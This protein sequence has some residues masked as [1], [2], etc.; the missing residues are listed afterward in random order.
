M[1]LRL[2]LSTLTL[3]NSINLS[4]LL[5]SAS[6]DSIKILSPGLTIIVLFISCL[7]GIKGI[8]AFSDSGSSTLNSSASFT[9]IILLATGSSFFLLIAAMFSKLIVASV[10]FTPTSIITSLIVSGKIPL[11]LSPAKVGN[12]GSSLLVPFSNI[13]LI[14]DLLIIKPSSLSLP[15]CKT[16]GNSHPMYSEMYLCFSVFDICSLALST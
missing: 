1:S 8:L 5:S 4:I 6:L 3:H 14:F 2:C 10:T 13:P 15:N 16:S 9:N 12:L 11:L 7:E